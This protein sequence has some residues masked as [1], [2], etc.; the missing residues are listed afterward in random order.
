MPSK[1]AAY[2]IAAPLL[3]G[4]R[5]SAAQDTPGFQFLGFGYDIL[6]GNPRDTTGFGDRGFRTNIFDFTH[7][8]GH[9]TPDGKW[10]VADKTTSQMISACSETQVSKIVNSAFSY[11]NV[12]STDFSIDLELF[13]IAFDFSIDTKHVT[14]TTETHESIFA[15]ITAT[16]AV[17]E[18]TMHLY[19]HPPFDPNFLAGASM[20]PSTVDEDEE[21]YMTFIAR[22]GTHVVNQMTLG[23]RW[24]WSMEFK[25]HSFQSLL[26]D[27]VSIDLGLHYAGKIKAGFDVNH[28]TDTS[29]AYAVTRAIS[30][31]ASFSTGG[32]FK[33]DPEEWKATVRNSPMPISMQLTPLYD[34][35]TSQ[36]MP[37][38]QN[39]TGKKEAL[40]RYCPYKSKHFDPTVS[41]KAPQPIP[42]PQPH[43]V[44]TDAIHRVCVENAGGFALSW[45]LLNQNRP[46]QA[47]SPTFAAGQ[48]RCL[49][50]IQAEAHDGDL[51]RCRVD[52]V[53]G[54]SGV[55]CAG[56]GYTFDHRSLLQ[57]NYRCSGGTF[58]VSCS[59]TGLTRLGV[60]AAQTSEASQMTPV[61]V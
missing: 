48:Y 59:F 18:L 24:G 21:A 45:E 39:V 32:D 28:T 38:V 30:H 46:V 20:L 1:T 15:Q 42:L 6:T 43:P 13:D 44:K 56:G 29:M 22:F 26:D 33:T 50:G 31:N 36:Y 53:A 4:L 49:D 3:A 52:I 14:D 57:A 7:S 55:P 51:L 35:F 8:Q 12:V 58:S 34:F 9:K 27:S 40:K 2:V 10:D 16:C 19:D 17:Y 25:N 54:R 37:N 23:G 5:P 61:F 11:K 60:E 41:C 47:K